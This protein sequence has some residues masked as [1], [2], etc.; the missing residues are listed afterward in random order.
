MGVAIPISQMGSTEASKAGTGPGLEPGALCCSCCI[1][2]ASPLT[3]V[4]FP[5]SFSLLAWTPCLYSA[6]LSALPPLPRCPSPP[7]TPASRTLSCSLTSPSIFT[8]STPSLHRLCL[9]LHPRQWAPVPVPTSSVHPAGHPLLSLSCFSS[10]PITPPPLS[11]CRLLPLIRA[12]AVCLH[13]YICVPSMPTISSPP[14]PPAPSLTPPRHPILF[15]PSHHRPSTAALAELL[16]TS[17]A[18]PW[19]HQPPSRDPLCRR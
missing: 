1:S 3:S 6:P 14:I 5:S 12:P 2:L 7:P 9:C 17:R 10:P 15:T 4:L 11:P 19:P 8:A 18:P 16:P 13:G